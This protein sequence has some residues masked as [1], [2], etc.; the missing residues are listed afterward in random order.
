MAFLKAFLEDPPYAVNTPIRL[1]YRATQRRHPVY[2][3]KLL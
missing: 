1:F 3:S 2:S